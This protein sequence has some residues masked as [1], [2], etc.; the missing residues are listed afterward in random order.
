MSMHL[1]LR[2]HK[3]DNDIATQ[4]FHQWELQIHGQ[5][6]AHLLGTLGHGVRPT[7]TANNEEVT[8]RKTNAL[9]SLRLLDRKPC[10][11]CVMCQAI[12]Q[13]CAPPT[14]QPKRAR[15]T[16]PCLVVQRTLRP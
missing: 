16:L 5:R 11:S 8:F 7:F 15:N 9:T 10:H 4:D 14:Q 13:P 1:P 12:S 2:I 6:I 3:L